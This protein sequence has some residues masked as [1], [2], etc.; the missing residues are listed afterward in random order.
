MRWISM[1]SRPMRNSAATRQQQ[2]CEKLFKA[3]TDKATDPRGVRRPTTLGTLCALADATAA[4]VTDVIDVFRNPSRSFLMPP[5]GEALEA[6]TVID[7]SHESL[8]RV[9]QRLDHVGR[10]G[11]PIGADLPP[12]GRHGRPACGRQREPVA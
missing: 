6:E 8:M 1:P 12:S 9:W 10:R 5:A 11:S 7:I 2:I 3:L 4:E